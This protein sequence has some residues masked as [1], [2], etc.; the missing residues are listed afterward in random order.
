MISY[1]AII[2]Y[3]F[4]LLLSKHAYKLQCFHTILKASVTDLTVSD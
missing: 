2:Y 4:T 1:S 3:E